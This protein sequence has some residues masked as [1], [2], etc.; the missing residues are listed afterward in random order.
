MCQRVIKVADFG[1]ARDTKKDGYT[2]VQQIGPIKWMPH[3]AIE[4]GH[5]SRSSDVH[6][7]GVVLWELVA[8]KLPYPELTNAAA[9]VAIVGR[10]QTLEKPIDDRLDD[11]LWNLMSSCWAWEPRDRPSTDDLLAT[12]SV[13]ISN[14]VR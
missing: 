11:E 2:T 13:L 5:Y 3:E 1:L 10:K 9:A 8:A 6:S 14:E 12:L 4:G 7:F